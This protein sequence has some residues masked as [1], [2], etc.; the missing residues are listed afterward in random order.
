MAQ[1]I[2]ISSKFFHKNLGKAANK[3]TK[4]GNYLLTFNTHFYGRG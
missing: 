1:Y 3:K 4:N 2:I